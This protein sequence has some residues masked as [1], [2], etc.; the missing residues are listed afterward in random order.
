[1]ENSLS[2]APDVGSYF[3]IDGT[4]LGKG[5]SWLAIGSVWPAGSDL[6]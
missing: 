5:T 4:N 6:F 2:S 3:S 1:M